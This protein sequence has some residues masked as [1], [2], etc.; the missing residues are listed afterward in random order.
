MNTRARNPDE[1]WRFIEWASSRDFL[2]RSVYEGNMNP[3]RTS[4]W[5]DEQF[6][7]HTSNWGGFYD[8]A[9]TLVEREASVLVTPAG[10]Y[11]QIA[12]RWVQAL[13][14]AYSG[15]VGVVEALARLR[16]DID[17]SFRHQRGEVKGG[18]RGSGLRVKTS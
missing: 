3:T 16:L 1:A 8:V 11:L 6:R 4:I 9:R 7:A 12:T 18:R 10:N 17:E 13:L 15:R 5:D 2:H 14:D